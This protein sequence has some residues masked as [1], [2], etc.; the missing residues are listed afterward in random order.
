M[1]KT[2][3][4]KDF[5]TRIKT[6]FEKQPNMFSLRLL[7]PQN[8]FAG[9]RNIC[10]FVFYSKPTLFLIEC[11]THY[12]NILPFSCITENQWSGLLEA[13]KLPGVVAGVIVWFIDHDATYFID[14]RHL[15]QLK[16]IGK[17]SLNIKLCQEY[18]REIPGE[19]KRV[20]FEYD[21]TGFVND[22]R[23]KCDGRSTD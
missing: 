11:K 18:L 16:I 1:S 21:V 20:F 9:V 22:E 14:I 10:D 6:A 5:E 12:G 7:D 13:S 23:S 2:N 4:G 17:K 19:K 8:G 3:R 15:Q